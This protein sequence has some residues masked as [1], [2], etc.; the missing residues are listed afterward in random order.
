MGIFVNCEILHANE[1]HELGLLY[2]NYELVLRGHRT[3]YLGQNLAFII[4]T[5][6]IEKAISRCETSL[7]SSLLISLIFW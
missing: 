3:I 6:V 4:P 5:C 2:L 7:F 1:I